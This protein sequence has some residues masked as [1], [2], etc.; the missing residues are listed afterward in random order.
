MRTAQTRVQVP[1]RLPRESAWG[2]KR[3][4]PKPCQQQAPQSR[5]GARK[6]HLRGGKRTRS[7]DGG[8]GEGVVVCRMGSAG[9][10]L[11]PSK[12]RQAWME[13]SLWMGQL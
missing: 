13:K 7:Q 11:M 12:G 4:K 5:R 1:V 6:G 8:R 3:A 10:N 9:Q 2:E